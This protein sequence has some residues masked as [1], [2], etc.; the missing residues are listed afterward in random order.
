M[1][2]IIIASD[3]LRTAMKKLAIA[4]NSKTV[5]PVLTSMYCKVEKG[6]LELITSDMEI[7]ISYKLAVETKG[8][9]FEFLL[10]FDFISRLMALLGSQPI[11]I[12]LVSKTAVK[13][14]T[15]SDEYDLSDTGS[16]ADFVK[17]PSL[18]KRNL[19]KLNGNFVKL[20]TIAM[21]T[22][23]KD[24]LRPAM[25][26]ACLDIKKKQSILV[27]TD[28]HLLYTHKLPVTFDE[29][30][31]LCFSHKVAEAMA[32]IDEL[33]LSWTQDLLAI[34]SG[35]VTILSKRLDAK[36]PDY[37]AV[38]PDHGANLKLNREDLIE[39]LRKAC[40]S[41]VD[42]KQT[43]LFLKRESGTIHFEYEDVD[44]GRKGH[45]RLK[46]AFSGNCE[47]I[48]VNAKSLLT[49]LGQIESDDI[50]LHIDKP[51][52]AVLLSTEENKD[53]LGLLMPLMINQ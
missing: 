49:L 30:D 7:T 41:S 12:E 37:K 24:D 44:Y 42:T 38:I 29:P 34:K 31:Q 19:I 28:A 22:T 32:G 46:G 11:T 4:I 47:S 45:L 52:K 43:N 10:P 35:R 51:T 1:K 6:E 3:A 48:S 27:S 20:I 23:S 18:P 17:I 8:E 15:D 33:E 5:L 13:I 9:P 21:L 26:H 14:T 40:L 36:F 25:T 39:V 16:T 50:N 2:K 53:Y